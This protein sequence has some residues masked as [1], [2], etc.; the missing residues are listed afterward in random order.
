MRISSIRKLFSII[1]AIIML[2]SLLCGCHPASLDSSPTTLT[3]TIP[4]TAKPTTMPT[5]MPHNP[6]AMPS[7]ITEKDIAKFY[8]WAEVEHTADT[9]L[10]FFGAFDGTYAVLVRDKANPCEPCWETVNGLT[11]YY[12]DGYPILWLDSHLW[13]RFATQDITEDQLQEIY[14]NYYSAYPELLYLANGQLEFGP[15]VMEAISK[16]LLPLT[17][18]EPGWDAVNTIGR[19][20][21]LYYCT[22]MGAHVVRW[23]PEIR[24]GVD[25]I[26]YLDVGPYSFGDTDYMQLYVYVGEELLTLAEAYDRGFFA[27]AQIEVIYRFHCTASFF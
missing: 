3:P 20:R 6:L 24:S 11:F 23:I 5:T 9:Q 22:I 15:D 25:T 26:K 16:A 2:L 27:D 18:E 8:S 7:E 13:Q 14:N 12:P 17:G 1:L 21:L 19:S 10:C 4:T